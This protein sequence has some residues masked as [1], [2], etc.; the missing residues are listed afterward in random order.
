MFQDGLFIEVFKLFRINSTNKLLISLSL[1]GLIC[2]VNYYNEINEVEI[3]NTCTF[4]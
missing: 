3:Y 2:T 4:L 1:S